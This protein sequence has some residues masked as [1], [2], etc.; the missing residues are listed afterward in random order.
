M[1]VIIGKRNAVV[2]FL[3]V[4]SN[5]LNKGAERG[6]ETSP[7]LIVNSWKINTPATIVNKL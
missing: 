4:Y 1:T 5:I 3:I 2:L 7:L 6:M